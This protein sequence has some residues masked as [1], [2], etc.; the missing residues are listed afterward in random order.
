MGSMK[1]TTHHLITTATA[2]A[3]FMLRVQM[4]VTAGLTLAG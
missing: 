3:A 1:A 2:A 4:T